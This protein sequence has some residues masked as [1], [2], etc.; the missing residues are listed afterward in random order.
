MTV[1]ASRISGSELSRALQKTKDKM[2]EGTVP[3][4]VAFTK[5]EKSVLEIY[6]EELS[7]S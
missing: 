7:K 1:V 5:L 4:L 3:D 6:E 2:G